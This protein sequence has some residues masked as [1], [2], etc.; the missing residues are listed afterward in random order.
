MLTGAG[1]NL[2]RVAALAR[3]ADSFLAAPGWRHLAADDLLRIEAPHAEA[4]LGCA[5]LCHTGDISIPQLSFFADHKKFLAAF[6]ED[7]EE[8][9]GREDDEEAEDEGSVGAWLVGFQ[10]PW[11]AP[12][13]DL[14]LW[15]REG[16]PWVGDG[17][18][19]V[20]AFVEYGGIRRPDARQ[21]AFFEGVFAALAATT[22]ADL[23]T[24]RWE[25]Q[26]ATVDGEI[27]FVLSLP[28]LLELRP[29][30]PPAETPRERAGEMLER[31][32]RAKGRRVVHLARQ[33]LEIWPDCA[34]AYTLMA[35]R[36][37]DLEAA[38]RLYELGM[39]AGERAMG[40]EAF[41]EA[42][43]FWEVLETRPYLRARNGL[44]NVRAEQG[45]LAEAVEHFLEMLRLN[46][47][48]NLSVRHSL[49]SLLIALGREE[50]AWRWADHFADDEQAL[51]KFPRALLRF[52]KEGDSPAAR[53]A[54]KTA[55]RANRFVPGM[56]LGDREVP[57]EGGFYSPGGEDEAGLCV[58]LSLDTWATTEGALDWLRKR[59][60][61]P[62]RPKGK[63]KAK[64]KKKRR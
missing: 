64:R 17:L 48:D 18:L 22:E 4:T 59:T 46:P 21:L 38:A 3:A 36:A 33:A 31:A 6:A 20:V 24:G 25:K 30:P 32:H 43:R 9:D 58:E 50:E 60:A 7:S 23:D 55:V 19:P 47:E 40:P 41:A 44:A 49:V 56:L 61:S 1:V 62:L 12:A 8:E 39:A 15:E 42:G 16:L 2:E 53:K 26:V 57:P 14:D 13:S 54:L 34:G 5:T 11:A 52:R 45:R 63:G 27:R 37:P 29:E 28:D 35:R 51:M 10:P